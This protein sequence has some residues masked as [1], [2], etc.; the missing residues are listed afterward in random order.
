MGYLSWFMGRSAVVSDRNGLAC[1][2]MGRRVLSW[3]VIIIRE[4]SMQFSFIS[5]LDVVL[6]FA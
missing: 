2:I 6:P 3:P 4:L 1:A 5:V